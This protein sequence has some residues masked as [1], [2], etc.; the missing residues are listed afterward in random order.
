MK[1]NRIWSLMAVVVTVTIVKT[2]FIR[3]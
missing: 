3:K 2:G 1:G